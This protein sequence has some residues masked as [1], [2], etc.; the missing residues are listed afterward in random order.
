MTISTVNIPSI[1]HNSAV[2]LFTFWKISTANLRIFWTERGA[3]QGIVKYIWSSNTWRKLLPNPSIIDDSILPQ[4]ARKLSKTCGSEF[5]GLK[6]PHLTP[7]RKTAIWVHTAQLQSLTYTIAQRCFGKHFLCDFWCAQTC[8]FRAVF[9]IPI[10]TFTIVVSAIQRHANFFIDQFY[11]ATQ[12]CIARVLAT[13]G[14]VSVTRQ[15]CIKMAKPIL[16]RFQPSGSPIIL[17][18]SDPCADI[19]FQERRR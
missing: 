7:Q 5:G 8:S 6:W 14:Q 2:D 11:C 12:I 17:V 10:R 19:Q 9:E 18:S 1:Q 3:V 15:Y 16:K 13:D 4:I